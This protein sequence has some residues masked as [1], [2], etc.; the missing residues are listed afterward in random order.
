M[1][2]ELRV[3]G[4]STAGG[5]P[6]PGR[7]SG[8]YRLIYRGRASGACGR[9][10]GTCGLIYH[11]LIYR[12]RASGTWHPGPAGGHLGPAGSSTAGGQPGPAGRAVCVCPSAALTSVLDDGHRC[13]KEKRKGNAERFFHHPLP[14]RAI[15]EH[16]L[17]TLQHVTIS[18]NQKHQQME[19]NIKMAPEDP[20]KLQQMLVRAASSGEWVWG[21]IVRNEMCMD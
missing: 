1:S 6:G 7:A 20:E 18:S 3:E 9:A 19:N 21:G 16:S 5:H 11:G 4:S 10:S 2:K 17:S 14:C 15:P 12:G 8:T 13:N